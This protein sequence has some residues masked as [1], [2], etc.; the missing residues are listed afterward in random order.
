[1]KLLV[2]NDIIQNSI[3]TNKKIQNIERR[4]VTKFSNCINMSLLSDIAV[5]VAKLVNA[6]KGNEKAME[7]PRRDTDF[8]NEKY[9]NKEFLTDEEF[10]DGFQI[11]TV[12]TEKSLNKHIIFL[13]GGGYVLR[14][15]RSHKNIVER[16]VKKYNLKVTFV[17][18]PLAPEYTVDKAHDVLMKAYKSVSEKNKED[19][20]Y[21]FGD[22]AGGGLALAFLQEA[23]DKNITPFP[24]KTV[25]MSPWLDVSM[26]NEEIK[27]FEEKDPLLPVH[28]L[29]KAG[30][31]YAGN[32]DVKSSLI[33]PIYGNMDNLGEIMLLFGTN[34]VLYP[35]C[36]K[37]SDMID[38]AVGTT[39]KLYI[40]ENLCHDWILAP[41]K[42]TD[43]ALD[44]IGK[45]YLE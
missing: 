30:K 9:F 18:Y 2:K 27:D 24:K 4:T 17:D 41:L 20:F 39:V 35:D 14:A 29:I 8:F 7:N 25:L 23:R 19:D 3:I 6:K 33:S 31:Q 38:T 1:M 11:I 44:A 32:I 40:G 43:E 5:P 28:S 45:F 13:H 26:T 42:E 37:L 34:E 12:K 16:M 10:I 22:S 36:M 15:V 21:F